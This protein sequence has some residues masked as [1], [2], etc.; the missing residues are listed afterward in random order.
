[1]LSQKNP[2]EQGDHS[3]PHQPLAPLLNLLP[4][5]T[6]YNPQ[7]KCIVVCYRPDVVLSPAVVLPGV[8]AH[9]QFLNLYQQQVAGRHFIP[10]CGGWSLGK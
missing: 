10:V 1:M 4:A 6:F 9:Y 7:E 3:S 2:L 8:S 5:G